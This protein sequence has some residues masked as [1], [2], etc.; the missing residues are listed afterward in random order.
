MFGTIKRAV[1]KKAKNKHRAKKGAEYAAKRQAAEIK[2]DVDKMVKYSKKENKSMAAADAYLSP[3]RAGVESAE[4]FC[5]F[6]SP[7][8]RKA[9]AKLVK[10][11]SGIGISLEAPDFP[12]TNQTTDKK[13]KKAA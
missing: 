8:H 12:P 4:K 7:Q 3:Y 13:G 10:K 11:A 5:G 2:G 6:G 1:S 9:W